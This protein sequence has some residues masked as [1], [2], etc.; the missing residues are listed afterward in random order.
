MDRWLVSSTAGQSPPSHNKRKDKK[1]HFPVSFDVVTNAVKVSFPVVTRIECL[2]FVL[3]PD[4]LKCLILLSFLYVS[5]FDLLTIMH[6]N[7]A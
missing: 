7:D 2:S 5:A 3:S 6:E 1:P 4:S